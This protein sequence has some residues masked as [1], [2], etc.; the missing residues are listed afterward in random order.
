MVCRLDMYNF[1]ST[2]RS[3][4]TILKSVFWLF[5]QTTL[6][7]FIGGFHIRLTQ[8]F[9][10]TNVSDSKN[11]FGFKGQISITSGSMRGSRK[12]CQRGPNFDKLFLEGRDDPRKYHFKRAI[13]GPPAKRHLNGVSLVRR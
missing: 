8:W 10:I 7:N 13:I 9:M 11:D 2:E 5:M 6:P 3:R 1:R 4:T 12:F